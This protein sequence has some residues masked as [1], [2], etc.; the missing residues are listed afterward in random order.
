[1]VA[2]RADKDSKMRKDLKII[3]NEEYL[4]CSFHLG[5]EC[6]VTLWD[7]HQERQRQHVKMRNKQEITNLAL[8]GPEWLKR[9]PLLMGCDDG[10][11]SMYD[12]RAK[13]DSY[14]SELISSRG[15][16]KH[17]IVGMVTDDNYILAGYADSTVRLWDTRNAK[18]QQDYWDGQFAPRRIRTPSNSS[19]KS[20]SAIFRNHSQKKLRPEV[21]NLNRKQF[22][23]GS[24]SHRFFLGDN[25]GQLWSSTFEKD[26]S[27][28]N[29]GKF[30][31]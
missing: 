6:N 11:I 10:T 1:M 14:A 27:R 8:M 26:N 19:S 28:K 16:G 15:I 30:N 24:L 2:N 12:I 23:A 29:L 17:K 20:E 4:A 5:S 18:K 9:G 3:W 7:G 25:Q 31:N 21:A 13:N 22:F